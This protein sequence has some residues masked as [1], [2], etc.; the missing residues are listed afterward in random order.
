MRHPLSVFGLAALLVAFA[1]PTRAAEVELFPTD[2]PDLGEGAVPLERG[3]WTFEAGGSIATPSQHSQ[4]FGDG[5]LRIGAARA[6]EARVLLPTYQ[7]TAGTGQW[8]AAGLGLK[9]GAWKPSPDVSIGLVSDLA[10]PTSDEERRAEPHELD[11]VAAAEA[12]LPGD[13]G[14]S[15]NLGLSTVHATRRSS[16]AIAT[17]GID[18]DLSKRTSVFAEIAGHRPLAA[19]GVWS[20]IVDGGLSRAVAPGVQ[21]DAGAARTITP[22]GGWVFGAGVSRRW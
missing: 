11:T 12:E 20:E 14:C 13:L 21:L 17:A 3:V 10:V 9:L 7:R 8:G 22:G 19:G 1:V 2:R 6:V 15:A 4:S 18:R 5:L 16:A